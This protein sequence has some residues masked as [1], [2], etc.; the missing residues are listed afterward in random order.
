MSR[1][2]YDVQGLRRYR[3]GDAVMAVQ[4]KIAFVQLPL[5]TKS[6]LEVEE[7]EYYTAYW[8]VFERIFERSFPQGEVY[9][10]PEF[11]LWV[12][13]LTIAARDAGWQ[14]EFVDLSV[15]TGARAWMP[16]DTIVQQLIKLKADV[17]AFS[18]FTSNFS[19]SVDIVRELRQSIGHDIIC[20]CGGAHATALPE[21]TVEAGFDVVVE[22]KGEK[23]LKMILKRITASGTV[24][25]SLADIPSL[26]FR[27]NDRVVT[28]PKASSR[29]YSYFQRLPD[30]SLIPE[31]YPLHFARVYC[32]LGCPYGCSF[33][34]D[35]NWIRMKPH[36]K[37][38]DMIVKEIEMIRSKY[39]IDLFLFGDEVFTLRP[40][41]AREICKAI[42]PL[43]ITWFCQTRANL[44]DA[45]T[46]AA[47]RDS[48]CRLIQ[49]G[50]E[51]ADDAVLEGLQKKVSFDTIVQACTTAK[52]QGLNVLTFWMV[53]GPGET[54]DSARRTLES[55][56]DL[57]ARGL[58][59]LADY[60][61]C[62]P[63]PGTDLYRRPD[64]Y[65]I[66]IQG[67]TFDAWR[68]D[69]PGVMR[70][71][72]LSAEEIFDLWKRGIRNIAQHMLGP[73]L[74]QQAE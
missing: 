73:A 39:S 16:I 46:L 27:E 54:E 26:S 59:D 13:M 64:V 67:N 32:S 12:T 55:I 1:W 23:V 70:T 9:T 61:I 72:A 5:V 44:V 21:Q 6:D 29:D 60:Y 42:K 69:Q 8:R 62:T 18:P 53:G 51:S 65:G 43:G 66:Q 20:I 24:K 63:Y 36:Y 22:G 40:E 38:I 56:D 57:F 74:K 11:P 28:T 48:G 25:A 3:A 33:C 19:L 68:E 14:P 31:D 35:T 7:K 30:F 50:A 49:I 45:M 71:E 58:T 37:T 2:M 17:Y 41:W 4:N 52:K 15:F 10:I 34:A 47:M